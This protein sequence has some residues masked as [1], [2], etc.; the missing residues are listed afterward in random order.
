MENP[1][2]YI[3]LRTFCYPTELRDRVR[4]AILFIAFG[5]G[6]EAGETEERILDGS[7]GDIMVMEV[8]IEKA[9][10]IKD[11]CRR[12]FPMVDADDVGTDVDDNLFFHLKFSKE[13]AAEGKMDF[14]Y[15][16]NIVYVKGKIRAYPSSRE[17]ALDR[18]TEA[19]KEYHNN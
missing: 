18:I 2:H 10:D 14:A 11:F 7:F 9:R 16:S 5:E 19:V 13:A 1:F 4:R 12:V 8:R 15:D 3:L 17:N 6:G